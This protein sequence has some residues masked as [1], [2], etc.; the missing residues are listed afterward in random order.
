MVRYSK[1]DG[2]QQLFVGELNVVCR[3]FGSL[4]R[5]NIGNAAIAGL[6]KELK[7]E[8]TQFNLALLVFY[9]PYIFV[10]IP[11]NLLVK[12]LQAGY[13]L[14]SLVIIWVSLD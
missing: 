4:D 9:I 14:P 5:A 6:T 7:L 12:R 2:P 13:Y 11:S 1:L 3:F 10:D 8:K